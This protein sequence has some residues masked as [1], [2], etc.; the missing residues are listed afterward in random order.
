MSTPVEADGRW[1]F[2]DW[3]K[4]SQM[5]APPPASTYKRKVSQ[6]ARMKGEAE[7]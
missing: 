4:F 1:P 5:F 3:K 2:A 7:W 6:S